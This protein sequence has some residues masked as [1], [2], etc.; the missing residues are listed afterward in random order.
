MSTTLFEQAVELSPII[1]IIRGRDVE[2]TIAQAERLWNAG[3]AA[4]EVTIETPAALPS[5]KAAAAAAS[6]RGAVI[7]AGSVL[8]VEQF[9]IAARLGVAFTVAPGVHRGVMAAARSCGIP[10]IPG[11]ATATEIMLAG[12]YGAH[13][14]KAFPASSLGPSWVRA[15]SA[16]F[17]D[18]R[19]IATGGLTLADVDTYLEAGCLAVGISDRNFPTSWQ[20]ARAEQEGQSA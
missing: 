17:P 19:V 1:A 16:P 18:V 5:L 13:V 10:H 20:A 12:A 7:G 4:V 15:Q 8:T 9:E 11:V 14:V 2:G 6:S 3:V